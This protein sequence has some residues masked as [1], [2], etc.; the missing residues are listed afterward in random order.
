MIQGAFDHL[1]NDN[2]QRLVFPAAARAHRALLKSII[3]LFEKLINIAREI[4]A[5]TEDEQ[6]KIRRV[7]DA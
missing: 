5:Y 6:A 4:M 1:C 3:V 7:L 2:E